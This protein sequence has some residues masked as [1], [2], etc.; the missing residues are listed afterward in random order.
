MNPCH[1]CP[2][3]GKGNAACLSCDGQEQYA[4][5]YGRYLFDDVQIA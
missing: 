5:P 2:H 1:K 4:Y 3:N